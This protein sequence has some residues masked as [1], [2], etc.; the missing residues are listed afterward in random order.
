MNP[1]KS[2]RSSDVAGIACSAGCA[3]HCAVIPV[4][5]SLAPT[6]GLGWLAGSLVHQLVALICCFLVARAILPAWRHHR[7]RLVA[8][9]AVTGLSLILVA[10][11]VL[12]DPCCEPASLIGWFGL[13][14]LSVG[15]L[16]AML[17]ESLSQ[18]ILSMQPYITPMGGLLLIVAHLVN[19]DLGRR[20]AHAEIPICL[21]STSEGCG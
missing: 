7:D 1:P 4:L 9:F 13:P 19:L 18:G 5:A 16:N 20:S 6:I 17:G 12:P 10:A 15:Q 8:V 2:R 21:S 11:F 14:L 3:A